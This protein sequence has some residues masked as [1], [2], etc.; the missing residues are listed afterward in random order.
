MAIQKF[1]LISK[2]AKS[3]GLQGAKV[4]SA[5]LTLLLSVC[6]TPALSQAEEPGVTDKIIR[7]G[8]STQ[9]E[10]D[11]KMF[12]QNTK[13]GMEAALAGQTVQ[14]R[15]IQ[16]E[17]L[18]DFYEPDKA[19]ENTK[20][21]ISKG[22]FAI[23]NSCGTPTVRAALPILAEN[24]IPMFAPYTGA[25]FTGPGDVLNFRAPY[26]KELESLTETA[27]ANGVKPSEICAYVQNDGFGM[28]GIKGIREA[29]VK[30][31]GTETIVAKLDQILNQV[32]DN[33]N[34]NGIGPVGVYPKDIIVAKP[35]YDSLK[36]WEKDSG[37]HCRLVMTVAVFAPTAE[38]IG[39]AH[40]K[41]EPW[42]FSSIS[43]LVG[44]M[45]TKQLKEKG[46]QDKVITTQVVPALDSPLPIVTEARKNLGT[47]LNYTSLES[48][49]VGKL[50]VAILQAIDGPLTRENF[51]KAAHRQPYDIGGIKVDFTTD[52][53]GSDFV[54]FTLLRDGRFVPV[55]PQDPELVKLF[56]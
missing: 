5:V 36:K 40:Y 51:L 53:Q 32:G 42:V 46:V 6:L 49:I 26:T 47:N 39:Y 3:S 43:L 37:A 21:L 19:I 56:K 33:P 54:G 35:G 31:P 18:N 20:Q 52:N 44:D 10:G 13:L 15:T 27:L 1:R 7:I 2:N 28:S 30:Q 4:S 41:N 14:K 22:I 50:F 17:Q 45:F 12:G 34:R 29:L 24:K 11:L 55:S 25:G 8:A 38:F 23:V 48:Y 9:L 16:F